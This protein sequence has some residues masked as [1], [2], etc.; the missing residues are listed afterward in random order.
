M[1]HKGMGAGQHL[2]RAE[3]PDQDGHKEREKQKEV[4]GNLFI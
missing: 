1:T 2:D 4:A 3:S